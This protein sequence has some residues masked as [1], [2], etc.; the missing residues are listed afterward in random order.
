MV[1]KDFVPNEEPS[2]EYKAKALPILEE[3]IM[4]GGRRLAEIVKDI[5]YESPQPEQLFLQ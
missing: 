3:R 4:Y 5:Y 1:Y 2:E